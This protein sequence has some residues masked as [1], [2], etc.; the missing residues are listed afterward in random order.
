MIPRLLALTFFSSLLLTVV[1]SANAS[2]S[3]DDPAPPPAA[4]PLTSELELEHA[5][6]EARVW[7]ARWAARGAVIR[8]QRQ[9]LRASF[10]VRSWGNHWLERAL[11]CIH[12]G[13][14]A[15]SSS[16]GNGYF[17]GLQMDRTFQ[18]TYGPEFVRAFGTADRWPAAV[19]ITVGIRAVLSGRGFA[20]W[21][22]TAREC[23][24]R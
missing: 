16:T 17:G 19:Q 2:S 7:R 5:Q 12:R 14:G 8:R 15:W 9:N 3:G 20:P 22:R 21:P 10:R 24:L 6:R 13:E 18:R 1:L 11:L 23:G 4:D